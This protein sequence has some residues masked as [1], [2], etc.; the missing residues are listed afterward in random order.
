M[1][2]G[3]ILVE[4]GDREELERFKNMGVYEYASR[5]EARAGPTGKNEKVESLRVNEGTEECLEMRC[6][7][8]LV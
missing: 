6:L 4:K 8:V 7:L 5:H 1:R 3:P 2:L